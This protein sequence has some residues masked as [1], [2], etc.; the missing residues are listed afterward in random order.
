MQP[1]VEHER[2]MHEE[3]AKEDRVLDSAENLLREVSKWRFISSKNSN[4]NLLGMLPD[5]SKEL[6]GDEQSQTAHH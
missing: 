1:L 6:A 2:F 4:E 3:P 5:I